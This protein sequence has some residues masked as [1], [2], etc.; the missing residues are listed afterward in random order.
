MS[1]SQNNSL[2]DLLNKLRCP[3]RYI[4]NFKDVITRSTLKNKD[5]QKQIKNISQEFNQGRSTI[6]TKKLAYGKLL[7]P[8]Q[9]RL[10][11]LNRKPELVSYTE[12][13]LRKKIFLNPKKKVEE[14]GIFKYTDLCFG[15]YGHYVVNIPSGK[16]GLGMLSNDKPIILAPGPHVIHD[17]N[18][19]PLTEN[20]L[21]DLHSDYI[22]NGRYHIIK[23]KEGLYAKIWIQGNPYF[24]TPRSAPYVFHDLTFS[25]DGELNKL[26]NLW[27]THGNYSILRVP[28]GKI[29]KGWINDTQPILLEY[30]EKP[31]LFKDG[32]FKPC[33]QSIKGSFEDTSKQVIVHGSIKR[34]LIKTGQVAITYKNG[35]IITYGVNDTPVI[36]SDPNHIFDSFLSTEIETIHIP[37][38]GS[39]IQFELNGIPLGVNLLVMYLIENPQLTLTFLDQ[40]SI[41]PYIIAQI[42]SKTEGIIYNYSLDDFFK[43][44]TNSLEK[45]A[46]QIKDEL[47]K[48][49]NDLGLRLD[50]IHILSPKILDTQISNKMLESVFTKIQ[51]MT[52]EQKKASQ[53]INSARANKASMDIEMESMLQKAKTEAEAKK[54]IISASEEQ[55]K[56]Y[57]KHPGL[58]QYEL[59]KLQSDAMN[60]ISSMIIPSS[61][62]VDMMH[63]QMPTIFYKP[64]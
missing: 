59:A 28:K 24:L 20:N 14:L 36:I 23:I 9:F 32:I 64:N 62:A 1:G 19:S 46:N 34:L 47:S 13:P 58:L 35:Q 38:D 53:Q 11:S 29:A 27:I 54:I 60:K 25:W 3:K 4:L 51:N 56:L 10:V 15:A 55:A 8:N 5:L 41:E 30:R 7:E 43:P 63:N 42:M 52:I 40:K 6:M 44:E 21:V 45:I 48:N 31:Y 12:S 37:N 18:F 49:F 16:L 22:V 50:K 26:K 17:L 57:E 2:I 61:N 39:Y 33:L